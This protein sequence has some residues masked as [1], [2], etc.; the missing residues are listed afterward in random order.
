MGFWDELYEGATASAAKRLRTFFADDK[1]QVRAKLQ[2]GN[3]QI[4]PPLTGYNL[5]GEYGITTTEAYLRL[6]SDLMARYAE[7]DS[8]EAY[9][10][11]ASAL[12]V[13]A[14]NVTQADIQRRQI[15]WATAKD[16]KILKVIDDLFD[17]TLRIDEDIWSIARS[18]CQ[19][20]ND[21][22]EIL[23]DKD[24]VAG[25]SHMRAHTMRRVED[26]RGTCY[27]FIQDTSGRGNFNFQQSRQLIQN[28]IEGKPAQEG[29]VPPGA[30]TGV[31]IA[32]FEPWEMVHFRLRLKDRQSVY[33]TSV[34]DNARSVVKRIWLLEDSA[35]LHQLQKAQDRLVFYVDVGDTPPNEALAALTKYRHQLNK[36]RFIDPATNQLSLK[37]NP[38]SSEDHIL[39]PVRKGADGSRID[40]LSSQGWPSTELLEFFQNR[41]YASIGM[42]RSYLT[43]SDVIDKSPLSSKDIQFARLVLRIQQELIG[44]LSHVVRQHLIIRN[45][46]DPTQVQFKINMPVPSAIY[47]LAQMEVNNARADF[48]TRMDLFVSRRWIL[49]KVFAM[50]DDEIETIFKEKTEDVM[51]GAVEQAQGQAQGQ[52]ILAPPPEAGGVP[53]PAPEGVEAR[54]RLVL[55]SARSFLQGHQR[56]RWD[57]RALLEGNREHEKQLESKLDKLVLSDARLAR[58]LENISGLMSDLSK[59]TRLQTEATRLHNSR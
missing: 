1:S 33:G 23:F 9:G 57:E 55:T 8:I 25:L 21:F 51:R 30:G 59:T 11:L 52:Q 42:P 6:E 27:G 53:A 41:L 18:T 47:E 20:G 5:G 43:Q 56:G 38:L 35:M 19:K 40:T 44:G 13:I 46:Y 14:D 31:Y 37:F 26:E 45:M 58:R 16:K 22:E 48:A 49:S 3:P 12:N 36:K 32:A 28:K 17:N 50:S 54:E 4:A 2:T 29:A 10:D 39:V 7:L 15:V 24:G 34:L